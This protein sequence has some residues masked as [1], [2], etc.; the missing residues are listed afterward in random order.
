MRFMELIQSTTSSQ[1]IV[2][3]LMYIR[4]IKKCLIQ[5]KYN[6]WNSRKEKKKTMQLI[7]FNICPSQFPCTNTPSRKVARTLKKFSPNF[8]AIPD[9]RYE[10]LYKLFNIFKVKRKLSLY[11]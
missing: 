10:N 1:R 6:S 5:T 2:M 11:L 4:L 9:Q 7:F 8:L 3:K